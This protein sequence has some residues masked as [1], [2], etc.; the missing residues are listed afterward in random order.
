MNR[1]GAR[2]GIAQAAKEVSVDRDRLN[3][4]LSLVI[5]FLLSTTL[6]NTLRAN[7]VER[8]TTS[9]RKQARYQLLV[10]NQ[11]LEKQKVINAQLEQ[12]IA[13][14]LEAQGGELPAN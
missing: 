4:V 7:R 10:I 1:E 11:E 12:K 6:F 9:F 5:L 8:K 2:T 3:R 14:L 13:A